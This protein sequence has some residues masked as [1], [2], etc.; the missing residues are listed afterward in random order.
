MHDLL[1]QVE[2]I[3][4]SEQ[5]HFLEVVE[6]LLHLAQHQYHWYG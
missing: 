2:H 6:L 1:H 3:E 5:E 4:Q